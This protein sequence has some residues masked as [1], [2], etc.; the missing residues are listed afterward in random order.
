MLREGM[1]ETEASHAMRA[2][3]VALAPPPQHCDVVELSL[4]GGLGPRDNLNVLLY[5]HKDGI[6]AIPRA[7]TYEA[8]RAPGTATAKELP[9][10]EGARVFAVKVTFPPDPFVDGGTGAYRVEVKTAGDAI[11]GAY[12]G[13]FNGWTYQGDVTGTFRTA[14]YLLADSSPQSPL[15]QR[16]GAAVIRLLRAEEAARPDFLNQ[17]ADLYAAAADVE[18][19]RR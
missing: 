11:T 4:A 12:A 7:P 10:I 19:A 14:G 16:A 9:A 18:A 1:Q 15:A 6:G 13:E 5:F 8:A 2:G 3:L 17:V